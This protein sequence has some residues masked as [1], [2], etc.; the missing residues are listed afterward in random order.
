MSSQRQAM[1]VKADPYALTAQYYDLLYASGAPND[2]PLYHELASRQAGPVLEL[3][4]GTGRV[5]LAL[6]RAGHRVSGLDT[7]PAMLARLKAKLGDEPAEVRERLR[8]AEGSMERFS[9]AERFSLVLAPF[10]A[11]QHLLTIE[12]QQAC[13]AC[14]REHLAQGGLYL[15][16]VFNPNLA[17]ILDN[18][19]RGQVWQQDVCCATPDGGELRRSHLL[20][21][22]LARQ[23]FD[24]D[25][26]LEFYNA[27]G[28]LAATEV[29]HMALRWQYRFE[30]EHLLALSGFDIVEAY[31]GY[32]K[33]PL[34][35]KAGELIYLC[36]PTG[37]MK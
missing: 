25:W 14:I 37:E 9:L 2:L 22:G 12:A 8:L 29:E 28:R 10:R 30:A 24:V 4:C 36:R 23:V 20:N 17:L 5:A 1:A 11:F 26:K 35:E 33:R 6:A 34:D 15:H 3:G 18:M 7:S 32:D 27:E 31:G 19:R 16:N 21:Y 13:L